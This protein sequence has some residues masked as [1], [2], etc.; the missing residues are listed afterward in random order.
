MKIYEKVLIVL[1]VILTVFYSLIVLAKN[2]INADGVGI[3]FGALLTVFLIPYFIAYIFSKFSKTADKKL[4][5][6]KVFVKIYPLL[7]L[8]AIIGSLS[9]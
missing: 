5:L 7:L 4:V 1:D 3:L 8:L 9:K 6:W 2:D